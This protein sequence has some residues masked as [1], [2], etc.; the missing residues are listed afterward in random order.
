[1]THPMQHAPNET[2]ELDSHRWTR[3][4]LLRDAYLGASGLYLAGLTACGSSGGG[5]AASGT[6][7]GVLRYALAVYPITLDPFRYAP[8]VFQVTS[9]VHRG[10]LSFSGKGEVQGELAE[11]WE[12]PDDTTWSFALRKGAK[13]QDGS[14]VTADDVVASLKHILDK[15]SGAY[16]YSVLQSSV[17]DI[18]APDASTVRIR[19][20]GVVSTLLQYLAGPGAPVVSQPSLANVAEDPLKLVAA[21]PFTYKS[22]QNGASVQLV[23]N[24]SFYNPDLPRLASLRYITYTDD[25]ARMNALLAG[26]VDLIEYLPYQYLE[27]VKSNDTLESQTVETANALVLQFNVTRRP[28]SNPLVR[29]AIGFA[30][31][32]E[33]ISKAAFNGTSKVLNGMPIAP[34]TPYYNEEYAEAWRFDPQHA[35]ELLAEA[36]YPDGFSATLLASSTQGYTRQ[37]AVVIQQALKD[38][39]L[40]IRLN[41][42]DSPTQQKLRNAG[43]YDFAITSSAPPFNDPDSL[44]VSFA[45][46][47]PTLSWGYE[48]PRVDKYMKEGRATSDVDARRRIYD[49]MQAEMLKDPPIV[50]L[51]WYSRSFG[52]R[53]NVKGFV[54]MPGFLWYDS[55]YTLDFV[56]VQ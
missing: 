17:R 43:Q 5:E 27:S 8:G 4:R 28:F 13:F 32:R 45:P 30:L 1:M 12:R 11:S 9:A 51:V 15:D 23:R 22:I 20:N 29:Q 52:Y 31:Q 7:G 48:N 55:T 56:T 47:G 26:D 54:E 37:S 50:P 10:L 46:G 25:A 38:V 42:P 19:T 21:G 33:D 40:N 2:S 35:R 34:S 16:L 3:R 39:G 49:A 36:G 41:T 18:D 53:D 24:E 14:P 6:P 44:S